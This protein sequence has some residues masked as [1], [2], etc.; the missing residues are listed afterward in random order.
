MTSTHPRVGVR[1]L[2]GPCPETTLSAGFPDQGVVGPALCGQQPVADHPVHAG[3]PTALHRPHLLQV[4]G[5]SR[6]L[7]GAG[8]RGGT[9][10]PQCRLGSNS[11][12]ARVFCWMLEAG[13]AAESVSWPQLRGNREHGVGRVPLMLRPDWMED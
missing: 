13:G 4:R 3:L 1:L 11:S 10:R 8:S 9:A 7:G 5:R 12:V 6:L 2:G